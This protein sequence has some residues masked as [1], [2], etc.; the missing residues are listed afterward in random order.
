MADNEIIGALKE[1]LE[2]LRSEAK[3]SEPEISYSAMETSVD[4][5]KKAV[6]KI[7]AWEDL[8]ITEEEFA[9]LELQCFNHQLSSVV[10][11]H[12]KARNRVEGLVHD[13]Q[14]K[15]FDNNPAKAKSVAGIIIKAVG[16]GLITWE[17]TGTTRKELDR[18]LK[19]ITG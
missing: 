14:S 19:K 16:M 9:L 11:A 5:I 15:A 10:G 4:R 2:K 6:G 12:T 3:K 13:F 17:E 7:C 8:E 1:E 18:L